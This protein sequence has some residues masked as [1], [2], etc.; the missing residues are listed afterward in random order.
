[1]RCLTLADALREEGARIRFICRH[2]PGYLRQ[3][4]LEH[5]HESVRLDSAPV[6][7]D[8]DDGEHAHLLGTSAAADAAETYR[9]LSDRR[10]DW[11]VVDHYALGAAWEA[12]VRPVA[13]RILAIDDL[14]DRRHECDVL[15]DQNYLPDGDVRYTRRVAGSCRLLVGPR[16]ALLRPEYRDYRAGLAP[17]TGPVRRLLVFFGGTDPQNLTELALTALSLPELRHLELD[18]VCGGDPVRRA[19]L[20][21]QAA[22]RPGATIHGPRPHL[23]DLMARADLAIGAGGSTTWERMC[24]GLPSLVITLADNQVAVADWLAKEGLIRLVGHAS[25]VTLPDVRDAV[26]AALPREQHRD[27]VDRGMRLS[28]G[29][30]VSRV[31][32][33][34]EFSPE[35]TSMPSVAG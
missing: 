17:R 35:L 8:S 1:M 24:L 15:L 26:V 11:L 6:A 30:G 22:G 18:V 33:A 28:D 4:L 5:G 31:V 3:R 21:S 9:A 12:A 34:L 27:S 29:L 10:W 2:L 14:A 32:D 19:S 20:E 16:Y 23:A 7:P 13:G 25:S